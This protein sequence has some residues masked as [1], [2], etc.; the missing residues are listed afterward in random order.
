MK[1]FKEFFTLGVNKPT[2]QDIQDYLNRLGSSVRLMATKDLLRSIEHSFKT[3]KN[4]KLDRSGRK[5]LSFEEF[6]PK[7]NEIYKT[8]P[9][10]GWLMDGPD[11]K[12]KDIIWRSKIHHWDDTVRSD[13][14]R[15]IITK[16]GKGKDKF[17]MWAKSDKSGNVVF[18]FG[19]KPTLDDAKEFASIRKWQ[20]KK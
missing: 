5:V 10:K 15:F 7:I 11:I 17:Q 18:H 4:L 9:G 16:T 19:D 6:E 12:P 2:K 14:T 8:Y 13:D 20:E 3:I 1:S